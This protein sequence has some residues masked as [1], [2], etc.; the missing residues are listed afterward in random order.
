[1]LAF[2][3]ASLTAATR[4]SAFD[5]LKMATIDRVQKYLDDIYPSM[6]TEDGIAVRLGLLLSDVRSAL[7][8]LIA[9][10]RAVAVDP[11]TS[12][13]GLV[14]PG[15]VQYQSTQSIRSVSRNFNGSI[16]GR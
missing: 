13:D 7:A 1:V 2:G 16:D 8:W 9:Q 3:S 6:S 12:V 5:W 10:R 11:V 14:V 4:S 15:V